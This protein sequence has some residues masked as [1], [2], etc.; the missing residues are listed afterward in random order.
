[1]LH[2][3]FQVSYIAHLKS[4][5]KAQQ[6]HK[7]LHHTLAFWVCCF[8]T[9]YEVTVKCTK[10]FVPLSFKMNFAFSSQSL[11]SVQKTQLNDNEIWL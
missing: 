6:Q 2:I 4:K 7:C 1:M 3:G 8:Q 10:Y 9:E 5:F 11:F